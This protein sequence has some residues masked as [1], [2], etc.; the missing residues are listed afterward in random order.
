M[1]RA[2]LSPRPRRGRPSAARL[3]TL[4][5]PT[6]RARGQRRAIARERRK[7]STV[8]CRIRRSGCARPRGGRSYDSPS[9]SMAD[10]SA[11][12]AAVTKPATGPLTAS[13]TAAASQL[14]AQ[15]TWV[16][17]R[18]GEGPRGRRKALSDPLRRPQVDHSEGLTSAAGRLGAT[19]TTGEHRIAE[20]RRG[21][22]GD[23]RCGGRRRDRREV[24][25]A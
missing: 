23:D 13:R 22:R 24:C 5:C 11:A 18:G 16:P 20:K 10:R 12:L 8:S 6:L 9:N 17:S 3:R 1:P 21:H 4:P 15:E 14:G 19:Q 25:G 7:P 2:S